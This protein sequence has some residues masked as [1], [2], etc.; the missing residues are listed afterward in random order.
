MRGQIKAVLDMESRNRDKIVSYHGL[1]FRIAVVMD[2]LSTLRSVLSQQ[3]SFSYR[4][5]SAFSEIERVEDYFNTIYSNGGWEKHK[6]QVICANLALFGNHDVSSESTF[7]YWIANRGAGTFPFEEI[8]GPVL[9]EIGLPEGLY[10]DYE[11]FV[12]WAEKILN[13]SGR[14]LQIF[15]NPPDADQTGF[16]YWILKGGTSHPKM[17]MPLGR[18]SPN[19]A[20]LTLPDLSTDAAAQAYDRDFIGS[21]GEKYFDN[22][23]TPVAQT[24]TLSTN[25]AEIMHLYRRSPERLNDMLNAYYAAH[26]IYFQ[27]MRDSLLGR[28]KPFD[29][30]DPYRIFFEK[31]MY[32]TGELLQSLQQRVE[33]HRESINSLQMRLLIKPELVNNPRV[34]TIHQHWAVPQDPSRERRYKRRL[35]EMVSKHVNLLLH[36][37]RRASRIPLDGGESS[38]LLDAMHDTSRRSPMG[39]LDLELRVR[40]SDK[41]NQRIAHWIENDD[42]GA[43]QEYFEHPLNAPYLFQPFSVR[44]GL[45]VEYLDLE[46][47]P[48]RLL[49][50][51]G[52]LSSVLDRAL[53]QD[54][55]GRIV[56][57]LIAKI[58]KSR[59]L[60]P[61]QKMRMVGTIALHKAADSEMMGM[62][63]K[64]VRSFLSKEYERDD[65][66][67]YSSLFVDDFT[68]R[69]FPAC[70]LKKKPNGDALTAVESDQL[71]LFYIRCS[72]DAYKRNAMLSRAMSMLS[73][74]AI[75][76]SWDKLKKDA[77]INNYIFKSLINDF[78]HGGNLGAVF[79]DL[80]WRFNRLVELVNGDS[81]AKKT[82]DIE[83]V[84]RITGAAIEK[85]PDLTPAQKGQL[86]TIMEKLVP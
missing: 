63:T 70:M 11:A 24:F 55:P 45:D 31:G 40:R 19:D 13:P 3:K 30:Q 8:F 66:A 44:D 73:Q 54:N 68:S 36:Q 17:A 38:G 86:A 18:P 10:Q 33:K 61:S 74:P 34:M 69:V 82:L 72:P 39:R 59:F 14:L 27:R 71:W 78:S 15:I 21:Q 29:P 64:E 23:T 46:A 28:E 43:F 75:E 67:H 47:E 58:P 12:A 76:K 65:P 32:C 57:Y 49:P 6:D 80:Q 2:I 5:D 50:K 16:V 35:Y 25:M 48:K 56:R 85:L 9:R 84:K 51:D 79:D 37:A 52:E 7:E 22:Q 20:D 60:L 77:S 81:D 83:F 26:L 62:L 4:W 42:V 41:D 1:P 53:S